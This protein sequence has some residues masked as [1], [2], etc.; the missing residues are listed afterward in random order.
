MF[1]KSMWLWVWGGLTENK[2]TVFCE[3]RTAP[4]H[5]FITALLDKNLNKK[6]RLFIST[7]ILNW[8]LSVDLIQL[9]FTL[10]IFIPHYKNI[11]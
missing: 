10:Q 2:E 7:V 6:N 8:Y 1:L 4:L 5:I 3:E 11:W 9:Q